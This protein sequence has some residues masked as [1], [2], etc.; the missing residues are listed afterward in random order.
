MTSLLAISHTPGMIDLLVVTIKLKAKYIFYPTAIFLCATRN[1]AI[2]KVAYFP[3]MFYH[4]LQ[5]CRFN[6]TNATPTPQ[7][8]SSGPLVQIVEN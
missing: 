8:H 5:A 4:S 3:K 7:V 1:S 6:F 2:T